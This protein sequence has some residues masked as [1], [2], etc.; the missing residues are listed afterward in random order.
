MP[1]GVVA[2]DGRRLRG[3]HAKF[4]QSSAGRVKDA[5]VGER[6]GVCRMG[7]Q[8]THWHIFAGAQLAHGGSA[9]QGQTQGHQRAVE[10]EGVCHDFDAFT[11]RA[12]HVDGSLSGGR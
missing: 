2:D 11:W 3:T 9:G 5:A 10:G 6:A 1:I 7:Q 8:A 12:R 4:D